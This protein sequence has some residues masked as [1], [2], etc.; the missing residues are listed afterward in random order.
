MELPVRPFYALYR[1]AAGHDK[2]RRYLD[3][4]YVTTEQRYILL[5][6]TDGRFLATY[7]TNFKVLGTFK[8]FSLRPLGRGPG[9][10]ARILEVAPSDIPGRCWLRMR[11]LQG[12]FLTARGGLY[13][14]EPYPE[15][16]RYMADPEPE[17][18]VIRHH[19]LK[20]MER[21]KRLLE[22]SGAGSGASFTTVADGRT[23]IKDLR[24]KWRIVLN[25]LQTN[26]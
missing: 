21:A 18:D 13:L 11:G 16:W 22:S 23:M 7:L 2:M 17:K 3:C 20:D 6:A 26:G 9:E 14:Q 1:H 10:E 12:G 25:P 4:V 5:V 19:D 15:G 24:G 8:P